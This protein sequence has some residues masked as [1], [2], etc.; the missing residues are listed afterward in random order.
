LGAAVG[1]T[2]GAAAIA[3]VVGTILYLGL[4]PFIAPTQV[5]LF[6]RLLRPL[7]RARRTD[8]QAAT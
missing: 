4:L 1:S 3:G 5:E 6:R 2:F 8:P 7:L